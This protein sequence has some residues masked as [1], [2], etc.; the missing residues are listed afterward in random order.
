MAGIMPLGNLELSLMK[1]S[2]KKKTLKQTG[3]TGN[4]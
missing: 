4:I 1:I 3:N 2:E